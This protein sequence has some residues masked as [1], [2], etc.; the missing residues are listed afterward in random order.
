MVLRTRCEGVTEEG[1]NDINVLKILVNIFLKA[2]I[3]DVGESCCAIRVAD[4]ALVQNQLKMLH[5][6]LQVRDPLVC[7]EFGKSCVARIC[8]SSNFAV[9]G[10]IR[11]CAV[12]IVA[13]MFNGGPQCKGRADTANG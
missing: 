2:R 4:L 3:R 11:Q 1:S 13:S 12:L 10:G 6:N 5:S 8:I 9:H 7:H